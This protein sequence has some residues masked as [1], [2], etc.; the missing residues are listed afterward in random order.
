[1]DLHLT[2]RVALVC[3]SSSGLGLAIAETLAVEG[4][5][6][7]L[8]GRD[9]TRLE[10]AVQQLSRSAPSQIAGFAADVSVPEQ[11][12]RLVTDVEAHFGRLDI[13]VA[14]AGGPPA[15]RATEL[16]DADWQRAL[17]LNLLSTVTLCRTAVPGMRARNWGRVLCL[18][19]VAA[20]QPLGDLVLSTTARAGV[21]GFA[22]CLADEI[23]ADGVT[24]NVLCPGYMQ[25]QR[26]IELMELRAEET[27]ETTEAVTERLT[28]AIPAR[29]MGA[30]AELGAVAAF[31][32]SENAAYVTGTAL[33]VDG[34]LIRS[35]I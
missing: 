26:S 20:K 24:V 10:R 25:T 8:N 30:P 3:G 14:N 18:T 22:K 29:R 28:A 19:S 1:M 7:A 27:G 11:A 16:A 17:D 9:A 32:A 34:G 12:V 4:C 15:G 31:L 2:D 13:L 6:V 21:L 33:Q 35:I 23:A 5:R